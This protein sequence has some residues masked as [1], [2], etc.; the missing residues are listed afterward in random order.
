MII[1]RCVG[2]C[3]GKSAI[4]C[5]DNSAAVFQGLKTEDHYRYCRIY[6]WW[7]WWW[8]WWWGHDYHEEIISDKSV[9]QS[10]GRW[11]AKSAN[12]FFSCLFVCCCFT[13]CTNL[14]RFQGLSVKAFQESSAVMFQ[15][16]AANHI[17]G[18]FFKTFQE[19]SD[20]LSI[21]CDIMV[22]HFSGNQWSENKHCS[23]A[24]RQE[25]IDLPVH[26]VAW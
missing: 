4:K 17:Q 21:S 25:R 23:N 10:Q 13:G 12:R 19:V 20:A 22:T 24:V 5:Q 18:I 3:K 9:K 2:Q 8:W 16:K 26:R 14:T 7:W 15:D 1:F 11:N 6:L